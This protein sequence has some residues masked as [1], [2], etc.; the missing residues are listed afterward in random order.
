VR[1]VDLSSLD[2]VFGILE[3]WQGEGFG[4][5]VGGQR[6][7]MYRAYRPVLG[8]GNAQK[9]WLNLNCEVLRLNSLVTL[10][11]MAKSQ[12]VVA[13]IDSVKVR[14]VGCVVHYSAPRRIQAS[15]LLTEVLKEW[16][17]R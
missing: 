10:S 14:E 12:I 11:V 5:S 15:K 17:T 8:W 1:R 9:A 7:F 4:G 3:R 6:V 13:E 2:S 16:C